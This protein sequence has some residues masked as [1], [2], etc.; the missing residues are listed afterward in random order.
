MHSKQV[1]LDCQTGISVEAVTR[2]RC[3]IIYHTR[4]VHAV[5]QVEVRDEHC[6]N[7]VQVN[8]V[9]EG[10]RVN[11]AEAGVDAAVQQ[12]CLSPAC[13]SAHLL[14][15]LSVLAWQAKYAEL[16]SVRSEGVLEEEARA[17][18][19]LAGNS[20]TIP[21]RG[22]LHL[23]PTVALPWLTAPVLTVRMPVQAPS[24]PECSALL[25]IAALSELGCLAPATHFS[26]HLNKPYARRCFSAGAMKAAGYW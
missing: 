19:L 11:A 12:H 1:V 8:L 5:L 16:H 2:L 4:Y 7:G 22:V 6:V 18:G 23:R 24:Y 17:S 3:S 13:D 26:S 14:A 20:G 25:A 9:E 15:E 10:Q 21:P